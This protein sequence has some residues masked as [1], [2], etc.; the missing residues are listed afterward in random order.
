MTA[1]IDKPNDDEVMRRKLLLDGDGIGDDRRINA[2]M[3]AFIK[4]C[5]DGNDGDG[6][7]VGNTSDSS[8]L[9][10]EKLVYQLTVCEQSMAKSVDVMSMIGR[11]M[12]NYEQIGR[13][14]GDQIDDCSRKLVECRTELAAAKVVRKNK[15]EYESMT[16]LIGRHS[17]R[18][19]T[20]SALG[21]LEREVRVMQQTRNQLSG[22]LDQR[23]Q[24]FHVM[25]DAVRQLNQML[26][27]SDFDQELMDISTDE[28]QVIDNDNNNIDINDQQIVD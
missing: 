1:T 26:S 11:E 8:V 25:L 22:K 17:D 12:N 28:I 4:W 7:G 27:D 20:Q 19:V 16:A 2:T 9:L 5:F 14:I 13:K 18:S 10:Y 3:K 24:Q 15:V 21:E 23:R 6:G